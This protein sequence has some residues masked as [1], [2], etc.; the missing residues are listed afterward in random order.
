[1][2]FIDCIDKRNTIMQKLYNKEKISIAERKWLSISPVFNPKYNQP[3]YM[4]DI[5]SV[6]KN[7]VYDVSIKIKSI[8]CNNDIFPKISIAGT[9]GFIFSENKLKNIDNEL[10]D[11]NRTRVLVV[12]I[13]QNNPISNLRLISDEGLIKIDYFCSYFDSRNNVL[14]KAA[15]NSGNLGFGMIKRIIN[16]N[17]FEYRCKSVFSENFDAMVFTIE[18]NEAMNQSIDSL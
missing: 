9:K 6:K 8:K 11:Y 2:D 12:T 15:S 5:I 7:C 17:L 13:D 1:M 14:I 16:D 18:W 10:V 4:T 3:I